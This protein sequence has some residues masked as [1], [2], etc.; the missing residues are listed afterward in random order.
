M[1]WTWE[2]GKGN[3]A[4]LIRIS[5]PE[6]ELLMRDLERCL[7]EDHPEGHEVVFQLSGKLRPHDSK[8]RDVR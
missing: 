6:V 4:L 1:N 5:E 3:D 2:N 8:R 7:K